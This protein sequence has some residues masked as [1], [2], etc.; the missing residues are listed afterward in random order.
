MNI[1]FGWLVSKFGNWALSA[2]KAWLEKK[3]PG[4]TDFIEKAVAL[5]QGGASAQALSAHLDSF[6]PDVVVGK[7]SDLVK[8]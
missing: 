7:P 3:W 6:P 8:G 1:F 4:W 2:A 5:L